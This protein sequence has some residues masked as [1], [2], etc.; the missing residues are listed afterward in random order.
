MYVEYEA[1][2]EMCVLSTLHERKEHRSL[3]FALK[4]TK[5]STNKRI[6]PL[7]PSTDTHL[8]RNREM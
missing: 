1:A 3:L 7:N 5:H 4:C 2:L 6:F 8:V